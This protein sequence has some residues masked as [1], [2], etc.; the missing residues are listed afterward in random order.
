MTRN[1]ALGFRIQG[2]ERIRDLGSLLHKIIPGFGFR[3]AL[4]PPS[5][6]GEQE[7]G[8]GPHFEID[9]LCIRVAAQNNPTLGTRAQPEREP[10]VIFNKHDSGFRI[11]GPERRYQVPSIRY[12]GLD[13]DTRYPIPD[14]KSLPVGGEQ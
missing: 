3:I 4:T 10:N 13:P 14:T 12:W 11:Q 7:R 9:L 2:G 8:I 5:P 1:K 6:A